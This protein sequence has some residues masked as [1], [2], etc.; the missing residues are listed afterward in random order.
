MTSKFIV[1]LL[2]LPFTVVASVFSQMPA[3]GYYRILNTTTSRYLVVT[4]D[5]GKV[6]YEA[7]DVD[8]GSLKT[9][10]SFDKVVSAP[11]SILYLQ[12]KGSGKYSY[13][14]L[15]QGTDTYS[16]S[17]GNYLNITDNGDETYKASGTK[18]GLTMYLVDEPGTYP[19]GIVMTGKKNASTS[20]WKIIP[21]TTEDN[22]FGITPDVTVGSQRYAA[23]FASF[24]FSFVSPGM[25]AYYISKIDQDM[26]VLA[27]WP[28]EVVPASMPVLISCDS[29]TPESNKI[30]INVSTKVAGLSQNANLLRGVY[31][32]NTNKVLGNYVSYDANTMRVLGR[33][34]SGQLGFVKY[35]GSVV[36]A[37][38]AYLQ[39]P[40]GTPNQLRIVTT[41][42]YEAEMNK[43]VTVRANNYT[44]TYGSF[45]PRFTYTTEG[46]TLKGTPAL[47][48]SASSSSP[49]GTYPIVV[50]KGSVT[51]ANL[52]LVDGT[53]TITPASLTIGVADCSR[54][55]NQPNPDFTFTY[56]GFVNGEDATVL[57]K[58]PVATTAATVDSPDG[59]YPITPSGAESPNYNITYVNGT[60]T[61]SI[62]AAIVAPSS[63]PLPLT[64]KI[65]DLQ[66]RRIFSTPLTKGVYIIDGRKVVIK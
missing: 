47:S 8:L 58:M 16:I 62:P 27:E 42:E 17:G 52:T 6:N 34:S 46:N 56:S 60:L 30:D 45:V 2:V 29:A 54:E 25:K 65:Y 36:P 59:T 39:V 1:S 51:N 64:S 3:D 31:F 44:M 18:G 23:F 35:T 43:P 41:E 21:V 13:S 57:T 32:D 10:K 14:V 66:G 49:V 11:G 9:Y 20:N 40:A 24:P 28:N 4:S 19:E 22:Y 55:Q 7:T 53:L 61:V 26:A 38:K 33:T 63:T 12:K 48:C 5:K 37:N 15:S 50:G